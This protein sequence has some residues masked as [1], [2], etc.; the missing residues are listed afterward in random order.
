[1]K[2]CNRCKQSKEESEF[3]NRSGGTLNLS[4]CKFCYKEYASRVYVK[5]KTLKTARKSVRKLKFEV[6]YHYSNGKMKC[7]CCGESNQ[8]F[9]TLDHI[10]GGGGE[11]RKQ[12]GNSKGVY[13]NL[14]KN[15]FP[16]GYQVLCFNC[17]CGRQ[18]NNGVC[19]HKALMPQEVSW[20]PNS[21]TIL[22]NI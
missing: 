5:E 12:F 15:N 4:R 1:M 21:Q 9:L 6:L 11:H 22:L 14:R 19:P 3:Y 7:G 10:S 2:T 17:N 16:E 8:K 18:H 20:L 13:R